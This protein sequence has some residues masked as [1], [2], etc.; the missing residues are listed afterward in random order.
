MRRGSFILLCRRFLQSDIQP[1]GRAPLHPLWDLVP[2][3]YDRIIGEGVA[4]PGCAVRYRFTY[5]ARFVFGSVSVVW[6]AKPVFLCER[7]PNDNDYM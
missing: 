6:S 7:F 4:Y 5:R 1:E 3:W 2:L